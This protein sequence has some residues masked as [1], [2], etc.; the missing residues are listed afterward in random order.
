MTIIS[1][2]RFISLS[3]AL[4]VFFLWNSALL[5]PLKILTVFFHESSH[6]LTTWLTGGHVLEFSIVKEEGGHVISQGGNSF[7]I[8]SSGYLGSLIWGSVIYNLSIKSK[9][10]KLVM[11]ALGCLL[12]II[13]FVFSGT[14][15][16]WVFGVLMGLSLILIARY[17][18]QQINECAL[19]VIGLTSIFYVPQDIYSDIISNS[20]HV[21][22][23]S[24][25]AQSFG[26]TTLLWG[27]IWFLISLI[28]IYKSFRFSYANV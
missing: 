6:A 28:L 16:A 23:A 12:I 1:K 20:G 9:L 8:T 7:L 15:F 27:L 5:I 26:G 18:P 13:P 3:I 22:D 21:S 17:L 25:L 2:N 10:D 19:Q 11:S 4:L 14:F 24:I